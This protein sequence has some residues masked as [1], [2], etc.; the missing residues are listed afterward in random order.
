MTSKY[1][2]QCSKRLLTTVYLVQS[3]HT[4]VADRGAF[5]VYTVTYKVSKPV[6]RILQNPVARFVQ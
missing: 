6:A 3:L 4:E 5:T 2:S 1:G